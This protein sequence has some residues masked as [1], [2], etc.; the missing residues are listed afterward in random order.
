MGAQIRALAVSQF[1]RLFPK[2]QQQKQQKANISAV[3]NVM[4]NVF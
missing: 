1:T 4:V 3:I 2:V